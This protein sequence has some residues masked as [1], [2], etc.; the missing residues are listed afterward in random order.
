MIK[1]IVKM[2]LQPGTKEVFLDIFEQ[3]KSAIRAREG[4]RGLEVLSGS[5]EGDVSIWTISL[6]DHEGALEAYRRSDLFQATWSAVKPL[7][8]NKAQ[9]WTLTPIEDIK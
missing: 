9:A 5:Q 6:W 8:A 7:F 3:A 4:C 2:D 1:R